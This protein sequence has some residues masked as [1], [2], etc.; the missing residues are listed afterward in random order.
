MN[1]SITRELAGLCAIP[2]D[3]LIDAWKGTT[4]SI[5][6]CARG[7]GF[8]S[9]DERLGARS[10]KAPDV[11]PPVCPHCKT[12]GVYRQAKG[13]RA[14]FYGCPNYEQ[15]RDKKFIVDAAKWAS[16]AAKRDA[17]PEAPA[18]EPPPAGKGDR[19]LDADEICK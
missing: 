17:K 19:M 6:H 8:G 11:D 2:V 16:D 1:G 4:K 5:E 3:E 9:R 13:T 12:K 7:R 14:A 18:P 15:H 10:E